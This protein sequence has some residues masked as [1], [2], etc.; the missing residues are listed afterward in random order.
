MR[1][2]PVASAKIAVDRARRRRPRPA[3]TRPE[4][5]HPRGEYRNADR[6]G[7]ASRLPKRTRGHR[8]ARRFPCDASGQSRADVSRNGV[9]TGPQDLLSTASLV[10][11]SARVGDGSV[12]IACRLTSVPSPAPA[13][14]GPFSV[15]RTSSSR[16]SA[17]APPPTT[18]REPPLSLDRE[19]AH[20]SA[21]GAVEDGDKDRIAA[22]H[23]R[24]SAGST[25]RLPEARSTGTPRRARRRRPRG[26]SRRA[27]PPRPAVR[28]AGDVDERAHELEL[29]DSLA[30]P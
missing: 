5:A 10:S 28:P 29:G 30:R 11:H 7:G 9:L 6:R 8:R 18:R 25:R 16:R 15:C 21:R 24:S 14:C 2:P 19:D 23:T 27:S 26:S 1:E 20:A 4:A 17:C 22:E 3:G 13:R 12:A